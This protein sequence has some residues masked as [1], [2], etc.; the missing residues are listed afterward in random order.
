VKK[1]ENAGHLAVSYLNDSYLHPDFC[2]KML[3]NLKPELK[4]F[5]DE[6]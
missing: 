5:E 1:K 2:I 6:K 3:Q 4:A